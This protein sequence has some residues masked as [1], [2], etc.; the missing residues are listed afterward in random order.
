MSH[1]SSKWLVPAL[2]TQ[3][4]LVDSM[5]I[6]LWPF[7][8]DSSSKESTWKSLIDAHWD[9][10]ARYFA[11]ILFYYKL[12]IAFCP[13]LTKFCPFNH[14]IKFKC[15]ITVGIHIKSL[16]FGNL[17]CEYVFKFQDIWRMYITSQSIP[18]PQ[19]ET[20][21]CN[22]SNPLEFIFKTHMK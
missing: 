19:I 15:C 17:A 1:N 2:R 13:L 12:D 21:I 8:G 10:N 18:S 22:A 11:K 7:C 9:T 20:I 4:P 6:G 5:Y 14:G 3:R 16:P